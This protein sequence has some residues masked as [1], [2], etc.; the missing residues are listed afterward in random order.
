MQ[1]KILLNAGLGCSKIHVVL[2]LKPDLY[3]LTSSLPDPI[4]KLVKERI[5]NDHVDVKNILKLW[6]HSDTVEMKITGS[7]HEPSCYRAEA[8]LTKL[9]GYSNE[10]LEFFIDSIN[11]NGA[12]SWMEGN[13]MIVEEK[14]WKGAGVDSRPY[15]SQVKNVSE[16]ELDLMCN[17][18]IDIN[19]I[20]VNGVS[21]N[22]DV[23][24]DEYEQ[25]KIL[26]EQIFANC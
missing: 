15:F 11:I 25:E 17:I 5:Y 2:E 4:E 10:D 19:L 14:D 1:N 26:V 3:A 6:S 22:I 8:T 21:I 18:E 16:E 24:G 23:R 12:D 13:I 20:R 9:D 7:C